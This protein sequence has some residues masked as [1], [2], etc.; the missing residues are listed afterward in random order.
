MNQ[1][2]TETIQHFEDKLTAPSYEELKEQLDWYRSRLVNTN[3]ER[4]ETTIRDL[5]RKIRRVLEENRLLRDGVTLAAPIE[6]RRNTYAGKRD[7]RTGRTIVKCIRCQQ[8]APVH[9]RSMCSRCYQ[10]WYRAQKRR[11]ENL[12]TVKAWKS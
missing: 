10:A 4:Q 7:P 11:V 3:L 1:M 2:E 6:V 9:G 12:G 5:R 8:L